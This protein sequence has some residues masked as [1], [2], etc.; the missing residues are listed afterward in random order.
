[1]VP[2][3]HNDYGRQEQSRIFEERQRSD[4][5]KVCVLHCIPLRHLRTSVAI[6]RISC[7]RNH[8]SCRRAFQLFHLDNSTTAEAHQRSA[9][10]CAFSRRDRQSAST[11][12]AEIGSTWPKSTSMAAISETKTPEPDGRRVGRMRPP[13][14][15]DLVPA[16]WSLS[17]L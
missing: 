1:M 12:P 8:V 14:G 2:C 16:F 7:V 3:L 13:Q 9:Q 6:V 5:S 15:T 10:H 17:R 4:H 11:T